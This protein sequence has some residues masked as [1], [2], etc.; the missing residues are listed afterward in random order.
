MTLDPSRSRSVAGWLPALGLA[1]L[2]GLLAPTARAHEGHGDEAP[3]ATAGRAL[4]RFAATSELFELVGVLDGQRLTLYLDHAA[5]NAPVRDAQ[6]ELQLGSRSFKPRAVGVGEFEL[7]LDAPLAEGSHALNATVRTAQDSDLLA[8]EL[9]LH[10]DAHA[11][12]AT[13]GGPRRLALWGGALAG[14]ALLAALLLT[15]ARRL[16]AKNNA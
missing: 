3:P 13:G 8:A 4:P 6:L 1:L 7:Q 11:E 12:A 10:E 9:D 14:A 15:L 16:R 2:L 5:D